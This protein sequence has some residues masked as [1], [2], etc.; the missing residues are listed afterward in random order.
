MITALLSSS[1]LSQT[2]KSISWD[3][4]KGVSFS[5]GTYKNITYARKNL[6]II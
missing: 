3:D 2:C 4:I 6:P 5:M 1:A